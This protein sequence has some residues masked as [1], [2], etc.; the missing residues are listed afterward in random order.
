MSA[1]PSTGLS[2]RPVVVVFSTTAAIA[3]FTVPAAQAWECSWKGLVKTDTHSTSG[4][5]H[6]ARLYDTT[7]NGLPVRGQYSRSNDQGFNLYNPN[8]YN[9]MV[10]SAKTAPRHCP[11]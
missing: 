1:K 7:D 3:A 9:T 11:R 2:G 4:G 6:H 5:Y 8:G 10:G